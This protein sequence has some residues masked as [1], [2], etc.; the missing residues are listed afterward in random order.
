MGAAQGNSAA[1][2]SPSA[3]ATVAVGLFICASHTLF[4]IYTNQ[5]AAER[6]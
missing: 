4:A 3:A 6:R 2:A 5:H 1:P